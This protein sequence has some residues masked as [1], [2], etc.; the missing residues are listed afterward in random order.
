MLAPSRKIR[1]AFDR[2]IAE[3]EDCVLARVAPDPL[4]YTGR[5]EI[6]SS[7]DKYKVPELALRLF[8]ILDHQKQCFLSQMQVLDI[9]KSDSL[10]FCDYHPRW[11]LGRRLDPP[12]DA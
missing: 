4:T 8:P 5:H 6:V 9:F 3:S 11:L 1:L 2:S 12:E 7:S 10:C